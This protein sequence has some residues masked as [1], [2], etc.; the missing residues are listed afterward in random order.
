[1]LENTPDSVNGSLH[2]RAYTS[3]SHFY[4][5]SFFWEKGEGVLFFFLFYLFVF[6][7]P[8]KGPYFFFATASLCLFGSQKKGKDSH[9]V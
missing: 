7:F 6:T 2:R 3:L 9:G 5:F 1:V 4:A 8:L